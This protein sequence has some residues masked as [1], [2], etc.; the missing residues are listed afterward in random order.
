MP[1]PT[2][3]LLLGKWDTDIVREARKAVQRGKERE[4]PCQTG[5]CQGEG[6]SNGEFVWN[7]ERALRPKAGQGPYEADGNPL[8]LLRHSHGKRGAAV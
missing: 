1:E 3:R 7:T 6:D 5:T 4:R 8:H 2:T